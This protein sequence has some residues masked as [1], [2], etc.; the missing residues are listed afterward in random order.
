MNRDLIDVFFFP[1]SALERV[2]I[3][4]IIIIIG[5]GFY[6]GVISI[7]RRDIYIFMFLSRHA[8]EH[9]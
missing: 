8:C 9:S 1:N 5:G 3:I 4:I 2:L 6:S 7:A